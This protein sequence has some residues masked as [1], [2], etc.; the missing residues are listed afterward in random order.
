MAE[1]KSTKPLLSVSLSHQEPPDLPFIGRC[2]L[3]DTFEKLNRVGEGTYG[4]VY[5]ARDRGN[6]EI[7]ALKKIRMENEQEG[8]PISSLREIA[9]LKTLDHEN[10]VKVNEVVTGKQLGTNVSHCSCSNGANMTIDQ[11][12][13]SWV[14]FILTTLLNTS[15]SLYHIYRY[16]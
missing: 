13:S 15:G 9:L 8:L 16:L 2:R 7:V 6:N 4:V 12:R 1:R 3:V 11:T 14:R 5:C 10:I